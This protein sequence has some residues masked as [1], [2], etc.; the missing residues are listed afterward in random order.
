MGNGYKVEKIISGGQTGVDRAALDVAIEQGIACGGWCPAGR[1]SVDGIIP[2]KYPLT[3]TGSREYG[4]RTR[5]NVRDSDAT[6]I[7][8]AGALEGGTE[9]TMESADRQN[10][11]CL[12]VRMEDAGALQQIIVWLSHVQP[13]VLNIAGPREERRPGAYA[14]AVALLRGVTVE[15]GN[16]RIRSILT[17][18]P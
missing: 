17:D 2:D 3:E 11:P 13:A 10:K 7:L 4:V 6:L 14:L 12:L 18:V 5:W 15:L 1:R 8:N 16:A 9:L